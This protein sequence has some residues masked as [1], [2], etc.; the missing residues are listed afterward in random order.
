MTP[1]HPPIAAARGVARLL[2]VGLIASA[3]TMRVLPALVSH[4]WRRDPD[5]LARAVGPVVGRCLWQLG[6]AFIKLGQL[7]ATRQDL[8]PAQ[9]CQELQR[10]LARGG[11]YRGRASPVAEHGSVADVRHEWIEGREL[12]IK[13]I[14]PGAAD[15]LQLDLAL[16]EGSAKQL[17]R[18]FPGLA[19]PLRAVLAEMCASVRAQTDLVRESVALDQFAELE[20]AVDVCFPRV[21]HDL[22]S[23]QQLVMTWLP[24]QD[25]QASQDRRRAVAQRLVLAVFEML[26]VSGLVHCDLHPGNWWMLRDGRLAMV[27]A[28]FVYDIDD[29]MREHFAEFFLGM[30][31]GNAEMCADHA[32]AVA[33]SAVPPS[34][35]CQFRADIAALIRDNTGLTA[36]DFSLTAFATQ[37]FAIQRR[38]RAYSR[39]T[40][41]FPMMALLAI[42][43]QVKDLDPTINFQALAGPVVLRSLALRARTA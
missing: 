25:E 26:F 24:G 39:A 35:V 7:A 41:I 32:L 33:V 16:L 42:E 38:H 3:G 19:G 20:R 4:G 23:D 11:A 12:A 5:R 13:T 37:L 10:A 40:F 21:Q 6:P 29:D 36:Q 14:R 8:F 34:R 27:D 15:Q 28:G 1:G 9:L 31:T 17:L 43:G 18:P 22:S 2:Q 30:S